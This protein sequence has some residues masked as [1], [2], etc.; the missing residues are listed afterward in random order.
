MA[1]FDP[2]PSWSLHAFAERNSWSVQGA[3]SLRLDVRELDHLRPPLGLLSDE[4]TTARAAEV[5]LRCLPCR[6]SQGQPP[7]AI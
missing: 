3:R 2:K 5:D 6:G 1:E 7:L 4:L